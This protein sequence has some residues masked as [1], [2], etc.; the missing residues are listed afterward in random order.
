MWAGRLLPAVA[1]A[2]WLIALLTPGFGPSGSL[3]MK[4]LFSAW[5]LSLALYI[6]WVFFVLP[7]LL[8]QGEYTRIRVG[9]FLFAG[10]TAGLG[11]VVQYFRRVDQV[12]RE[13]AKVQ[14]QS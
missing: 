10:L 5:V 2:F 9:Y 14:N 7:Q 12:L 13:M 6:V 3:L 1:W 4:V 8:F 11:P